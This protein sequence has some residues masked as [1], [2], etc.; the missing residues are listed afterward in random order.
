M[1]RRY[2]SVP[3]VKAQYGNGSVLK[4]A[5]RRGP[6]DQLKTSR[7]AGWTPARPL[8][9]GVEYPPS[10]WTRRQEAAFQLES[11]R[12]FPRVSDSIGPRRRRTE[13]P[14]LWR[15]RH[16]DEV[17]RLSR[18]GAAAL[19]ALEDAPAFAEV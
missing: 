1:S 14:R 8:E 12:N 16:E 4:G 5:G 13:R 7:V 3:P 9:E 2:D 17:N 19:E 6:T 10:V 18:G 11:A 15:D